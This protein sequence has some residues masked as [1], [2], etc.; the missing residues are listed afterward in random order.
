MR[1]SVHCIAIFI[2]A[3]Y[4]T[5]FVF[6]CQSVPLYNI[7]DTQ[8]FH[9][10]KGTDKYYSARNASAIQLQLSPYYQ[11]AK[12]GRNGMG[13]KVAA[14][15][16]Y[17]KW[18]MLGVFFGTNG[19]PTDQTIPVNYQNINN[20]KTQLGYLALPDASVPTPPGATNIAGKYQRVPDGNGGYVDFTNENQYNPERD[21]VGSYDSVMVRYERFGLRTQLTFDFKFGL[22]IGM[23]TGV[24]DYKQKPEFNLSNEFRKDSGLSYFDLKDDGVTID[25]TKPKPPLTD[26]SDPALD[27]SARHILRNLMDEKSRN[28]LAKDLGL[29]LTEVRQTKWEDSHLYLYWQ[30]PFDIPD[31]DGDFVCSIIP[32]I[33]AGVWLPTGEEKNQNQ[34]FSLA[35]G[36][37]GFTM[38]TLEGALLFDFPRMIQTS[39][40]GGIM[41][42]S[43]RDLPGYRVPTSTFQAGIIPWKTTIR[44][45]PGLTWYLNVSFKAD[46]FISTLSFYFDWL[47]TRHMKDSITLKEPDATRSAAFAVGVPMLERDSE[48]KNQQVHFGFDYHVTP[49]LAFGFGV[50]S[51]ISGV[52]V[53]RTSTI[54]GTASLKF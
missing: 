2:Q 38:F 21:I 47:Y 22:G 9:T 4:L 49:L 16:I 52:R 46:D 3:V 27:K 15:D 34:P 8:P 14:G 32:Y 20:S 45:H 31:K 10:V 23:R 5:L 13:T 37:D 12:S 29:D 1:K 7:Q 11:H 6:T 44:K 51:Y 48:W 25:Y 28:L 35:T 17:G 33:S 19:V 24:A 54:M 26:T 18:N 40:G 36:N 53:Y 30:Y 39:L 50:Q 43:E 41:I 42:A